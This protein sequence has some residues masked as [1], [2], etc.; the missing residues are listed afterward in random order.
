MDLLM[1]DT[2]LWVGFSFLIFVYIIWSKGKD[3]ITAILDSRIEGIKQEI[4]TAENLRTEAQE[5]LAQYQR[6]HRNAVV[7]AAEIIANA[8]KHADVILKDSEKELRAN[9]KRR[10][11]QLEERLNRMKGAAIAQIQQH[12]ANLAIEATRDIIAD[13]LNKKANE[14]LVDSSIKN[15]NK[16]VG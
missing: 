16:S 3:A 15:L 9:M 2:N 1:H 14:N 6:K 10:E 4:E 8:E 13:K 12:A 7:E 11:K 5:L